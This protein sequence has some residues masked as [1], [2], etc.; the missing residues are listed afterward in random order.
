MEGAQLEA[1]SKPGGLGGKEAENGSTPCECLP[2]P[3]GAAPRFCSSSAPQGLAM[4][5]AEL[6]P[7]GP[8]SNLSA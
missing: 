8:P 2:L 4:L 7:S 6:C 5:L 1:E 3:A